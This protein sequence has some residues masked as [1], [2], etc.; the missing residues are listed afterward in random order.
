MCRRAVFKIPGE[1]VAHKK[2]T[3]VKIILGIFV[4]SLDFEKAL[5]LH[6]SHNCAV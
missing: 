3:D 2:V 5:Y 4:R 6:I 1:Q